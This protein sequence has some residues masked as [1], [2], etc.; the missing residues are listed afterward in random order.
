MVGTKAQAPAADHV[1]AK[2]QPNKAANDSLSAA[3]P[4]APSAA[5]AAAAEAVMAPVIHSG[6]A[7]EAFLAPVSDSG[8]AAV[9]SAATHTDAAQAQPAK[10]NA[11]V[12]QTTNPL[13][14]AVQTADTG[15][16]PVTQPIQAQ[17]EVP[18]TVSKPWAPAAVKPV[19]KEAA[20]QASK[21]APRVLRVNSGS[22]AVQP[23]AG[24]TMPTVTKSMAAATEVVSHAAAPEAQQANP[25]AQPAVP[26]DIDLPSGDRL[27]SSIDAGQGQN[28]QLG[29]ADAA[30][31]NSIGSPPVQSQGIHL[32]DAADSS[33]RQAGKAAEPTAVASGKQFDG[34]AAAPGTRAEAAAAAAAAAESQGRAEG[35]AAM[36]VE[37]PDAAKAVSPVDG[38]GQVA[39]SNTVPARSKS[40][41]PGKPRGSRTASEQDMPRVARG[42]SS[43]AVSQDRG[44]GR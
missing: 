13:Y 29:K 8:A 2:L 7:A 21:F 22:K 1:A 34:I 26:M 3:P 5:P 14:E 23:S 31:P 43:Q 15:L 39:G 6:A 24:T 11:A 20:S 38:Q 36:A 16:K 4:A 30:E 17:A 32:G 12:L 28:A 41:D 35:K 25:S 9:P 33:A 44:R 40:G 18:I 27:K 10:P 19:A 37:Q 42:A